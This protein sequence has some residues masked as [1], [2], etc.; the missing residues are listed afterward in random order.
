MEHAT[1]LPTGLW[2]HRSL[3]PLPPISDTGDL[4]WGP[5]ICFFD[6]FPGDAA[7]AAA[8][9]IVFATTG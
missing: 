2:K 9:G 1:D 6:K 7:A 3:H 4:N 8:A 5:G